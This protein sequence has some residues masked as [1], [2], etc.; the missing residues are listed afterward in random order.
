M[1]KPKFY[2]SEY[3]QGVMRTPYIEINPLYDLY[4]SPLEHASGEDAEKNLIQVGKGETVER[5]G[6]TITFVDFDVGSHA[7]N[8][9]ISVGAI[10]EVERDG[11]KQT[12][13]P[14]MVMGGIEEGQIKRMVHLPGGADHLTLE[15]ID[16]DRK[17]VTLRL[18][19]QDEKTSAEL[20]VLS[21]GKKPLINLF[22][23]GTILVM[24][25]LMVATYRRARES[26]AA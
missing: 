4:L 8:G 2:F 22:W 1:A 18:V 19:L 20:L 9:E 5:E 3:N 17:I 24:A 14:T 13:T 25:G 11:D 12:L 21:V 10:L 15:S 23:L 16:A 26:R 6:Y 7:Q